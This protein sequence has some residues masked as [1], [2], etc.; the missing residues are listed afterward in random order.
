M[1]YVWKEKSLG[2]FSKL[3]RIRILTVGKEHDLIK[4]S[5]RGYKSTFMEVAA[6]LYQIQISITIS[7]TQFGKSQLAAAEIKMADLRHYQIW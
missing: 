2:E 1:Y 5:C 4:F 7:Q 6:Q 3:G